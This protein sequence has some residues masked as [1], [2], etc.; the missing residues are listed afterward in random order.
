MIC[1]ELCNDNGKCF[2]I[3]IHLDTSAVWPQTEHQSQ[4]AM[5]ICGNTGTKHWDTVSLSWTVRQL[6]HPANSWQYKW[7]MTCGPIQLVNVMKYA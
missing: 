5:A 2:P 7:P 1:R 4:E 3:Y 6:P